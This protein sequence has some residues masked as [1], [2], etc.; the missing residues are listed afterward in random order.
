MNIKII[1]DNFHAGHAKSHK[2]NGKV[3]CDNLRPIC[4]DWQLSI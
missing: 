4:Y 2:D 3:N 1:G